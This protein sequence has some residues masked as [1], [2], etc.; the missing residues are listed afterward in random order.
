MKFVGDFG[1]T[2]HASTVLIGEKL[3]LYKR[4]AESG[5]LSPSE[6]ATKTHTNDRYI[7]EWLSAQAAAGY[8]MY[9]PKSGK[10]SMSPEQAFTL[11]DENSPAYLPGAFYVAASMFKA[12]P[13]L[14]E[15]FRTGKGFGWEEHSTDLFVGAEKFFRPAYSGNL[16]SNWLPALQGV[17]AKLKAGAL[18]ADVGCGYGASTI[19]MAKA[20][21]KSKFAGYDFHKPSIEYARKSAAASGVSS[22]VSFE[23][24]KAQDYPK[25][26]F[27]LV[28][29]F[30]CLHDMGDPA[31]AAKHVRQS[32]K[33]DGTWMIVEPYANE[34]T[35]DNLN[36][37]GR[38]YY[39]ASTMICTPASKAQE[40][41]L[42]LGAQASDSRLRE[43]VMS[44]GFKTFRRATETPFNR[45][46]EAK[47]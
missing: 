14:T 34:R 22:Q 12:E 35:E 2:L 24:A 4:L 46:F 45:V 7:R 36:P 27:D 20:F 10:Y 30:D 29:F 19:I 37:V 6:L 13:T 17:V 43:V 25:K 42:A 41:G 1:A 38:I 23:V 26:D 32:M 5:G 28:T 15:A 21:P 47:P 11:A 18:V 33:P 3:G 16:V 8:V 40:V 31:G 9:D 39:S 44:G